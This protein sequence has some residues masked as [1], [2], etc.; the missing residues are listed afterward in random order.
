[1]ACLSS[2]LAFLFSKLDDYQYFRISQSDFDV[3]MFGE[4]G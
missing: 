1:M 3:M 2:F 4:H